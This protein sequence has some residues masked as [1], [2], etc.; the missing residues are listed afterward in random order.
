[1]E[2]VIKH[3]HYKALAWIAIVTFICLAF[4]FY[5]VYSVSLPTK[6]IISDIRTLKIGQHGY[7]VN[8]ALYEIDGNYYLKSDYTV[9]NRNGGTSDT[10]IERQDKLFC[11][12]RKYSYLS[13]LLG[14]EITV[15]VS[16]VVNGWSGLN[17]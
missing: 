5:S 3:L 17:E 8:W 14:C 11:I 7:I 15:P 9:E 4:S 6:E 10:Y 12:I 2:N 16:N 1:M 13:R